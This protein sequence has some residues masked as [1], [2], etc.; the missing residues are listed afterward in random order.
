SSSAN[1]ARMPPIRALVIRSLG[2]RHIAEDPALTP[3]LGIRCSPTT[4][5]KASPRSLAYLSYCFRNGNFTTSCRYR[6]NRP[7]LNENSRSASLRD[8]GV[9]AARRESAGQRLQP[10]IMLC[11]L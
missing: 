10:A 8:G 2:Y 5:P 9:L 4:A 3:V 1:V 7:T 11:C 6:R